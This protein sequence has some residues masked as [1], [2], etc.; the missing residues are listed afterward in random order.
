[1]ITSL[2]ATSLPNIGGVGGGIEVVVEDFDHRDGVA[3]LAGLVAEAAEAVE[4]RG[5]ALNDA[6]N[7]AARV[8]LGHLWEDA[9]GVLAAGDG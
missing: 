4:E 9:L 1:M 2:E 3:Y 7:G 8:L 6:R 5:I